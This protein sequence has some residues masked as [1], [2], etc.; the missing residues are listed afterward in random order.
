MALVEGKEYPEQL[1]YDLDNQIWYEPL[2]DGG[3]PQQGLRRLL[4]SSP[5]KSLCSRPSGSAGTSRR[6]DLSRL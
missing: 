3:Y 5:V 1:Y 2:E 4:L 6:S